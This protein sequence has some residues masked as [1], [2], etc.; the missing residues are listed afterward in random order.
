[1]NEQL[2]RILN[3]YADMSTTCWVSDSN[4]PVSECWCA[5][6]A[7]GRFWYPVALET[8]QLLE[9]KDNVIK[10]YIDLKNKAQ[11]YIQASI[12]RGD[13]ESSELEEPFWEEL[14]EIMDLNLKRTK[15]VEV[16]IT[17][18]Y[19]GSAT[20]PYDCDIENDIDV[21]DLSNELSLTLNGETIEDQWV[22]FYSQEIEEA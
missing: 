3:D 18:V 10:S 21:E 13:W 17:V 19:T 8:Q 1:M 2:Q 12:D 15:E 6:C 5:Q 7:E 16:R 9:R 20:V 22:T 14:A 11:G 4:L